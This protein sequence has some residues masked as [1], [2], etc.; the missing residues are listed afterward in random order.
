MS[1]FLE[2]KIRE[3]TLVLLLAERRL[4]A[5]EIRGLTPL[6]RRQLRRALLQSLLRN[7]R[8]TLNL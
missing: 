3:E 1:S 2:I 7:S 6:A 5:E 4:A 8:I